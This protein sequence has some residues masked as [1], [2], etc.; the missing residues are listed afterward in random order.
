MG[1]RV[2]VLAACALV[3]AAGADAKTQLF[4]SG[5]AATAAS[6]TT[7]LDLRGAPA[8][9]AWAEVTTY[10]PS[11]YTINLGQLPGRRIGTVVAQAQS[12]LG[13][14]IVGAAGPVLVA[15]PNDA[16]VKQTA[17]TCT[18]TAVHAAVWVLRI[19]VSTQTIDVPVYVDPTTGGE[20]GFGSAKLVSC[21]PQPYASSLPHYAPLGTK[22]SDVKTTLSA[23]VFTNPLFGGS[24]VW[25]TV[26]TP[27]RTDGSA[28]ALGSAVEAQG[29][30]GVPAS[31]SLKAKVQTTRRANRVT[32]S[33]LLSGT[34]L[35]NLRGVADANVAF[36]GNDRSAGSAKTIASGTFSRKRALGQRTSFTAT[37]TVPTREF[38]CVAPLP[39][40]LA[41]AGCVSATR[42]GYRLRSNSVLVT[43]R[44]R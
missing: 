23:G 20:T 29:L 25:R 26:V 43:P 10:V 42:A 39:V 4:V 27:W 44:A 41:P 36:F 16:A 2:L 1:R 38:S 33:V 7:T 17:T 6:G 24:L 11:G 28:P 12:L 15:D 30:V 31:L 37:A 32:N 19:V 13:A 21:F 22:L 18:H 35:E 9:T 3:F 5:P 40:T 34:V 14:P 8:D